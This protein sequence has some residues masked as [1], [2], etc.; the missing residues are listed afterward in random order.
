LKIKNTINFYTGLTFFLLTILF[1]VF[2]QSEVEVSGL[3]VVRGHLSPLSCPSFVLYLMAF[4]ALLLMLSSFW[5]TKEGGVTGKV[6]GERYLRALTGVV[7]SVVYVVLMQ[8]IGY[9][10][11]SMT[12][13]ASY[14]IFMG[15]RKYVAVI[16]VSIV[17]PLVL[18]Y[19]F[20][21]LMHVLFP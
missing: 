2:A 17:V 15:S 7:F 21:E 9:L 11:A 6:E 5:G 13:L 14:I 1:I 12:M 16:L 3:R 10:A 20:G 4:L 19:V 8:V 18:Y